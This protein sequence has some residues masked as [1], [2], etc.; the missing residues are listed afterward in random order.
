MGAK[1]S[2]TGQKL[3]SISE[4]EPVLFRFAR[5]DEMQVGFGAAPQRY[6]MSGI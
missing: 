3:Q 6:P 5:H 4:H 1:Q 2:Q